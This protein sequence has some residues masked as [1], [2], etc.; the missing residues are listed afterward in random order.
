MW[1]V[2]FLHFYCYGMRSA[3]L[4]INEY[5]DDDDDDDDDEPRRD[6][7][8]GHF[9]CFFLN[10]CYSTH[11]HHVM[12]ATDKTLLY[13]ICMQLVLVLFPKFLL[14]VVSICLDFNPFRCE[15]LPTPPSDRQFLLLL[16]R[17]ICSVIS[18]HA[19]TAALSSGWVTSVT[20]R[21]SRLG[22]WRITVTPVSIPPR[23]MSQSSNFQF[24]LL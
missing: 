6:W 16:C 23:R 7:L 2:H 19:R 3:M 18:A 17:S 9:V 14:S 1:C 20:P 12:M 22:K 5:D 11:C 24:Q 8:F 4:Q 21:P 13:C 10:W 15:I